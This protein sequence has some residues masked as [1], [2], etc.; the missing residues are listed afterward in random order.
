[1]VNPIVAEQI[2]MTPELSQQHQRIFIHQLN[3]FYIGN[4]WIYS[5]MST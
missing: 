1:M 3:N 2:Y 5:S 4:I